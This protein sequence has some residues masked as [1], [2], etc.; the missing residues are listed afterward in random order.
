MFSTTLSLSDRGLH[1]GDGLFE[2]MAVMAGQVRLLPRHL[3]RLAHGAARLAIP[4]PDLSAL[5]AA[6]QE[7]A[8]ALGEGVLKLIVTRGS[9]GRGYA[10]P[11]DAEPMLILLRY[12]QKLPRPDD[13]QAGI[14][15][16]LCTLRLAR[17]PVLAGMKHLNR[18]EYVLARAEWREPEIAEGLLLDTQDELIE[19]VTSNI[20]LVQAGRLRTPCLDQCGVAGVMRAEVLACAERLGL[21]VEEGRL[22]LDDVLAADEVFLTNSLHVMRPVRALHGYREWVGGTLV[23]R[24]QQ[25]LWSAL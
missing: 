11:E 6:L 17:Q 22:H 15:L 5:E 4:L 13:A 12:P 8:Q 23:P 19:A 10:P 25:T 20:F 16:R 3:H 24:L 9:G 7:A 14:V 18:L 1:Y 21:E 2:T